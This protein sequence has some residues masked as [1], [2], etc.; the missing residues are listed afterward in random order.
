MNVS[1]RE[2]VLLEA[3]L[4]AA[5]FGGTAMLAR[6]K[7]ED[8]KMIRKE[9][10]QLRTEIEGDQRLLTHR[11]KWEVQFDELK[12][13]LPEH[14]AEQQVD[15][16]WM[17]LMQKL[18][19]K[20]QVDIKKRQVLAEI[21]SGDVYEL[22][23]LCVDWEANLSSIVRFLYDLQSQGGTLDVRQLTIKPTVKKKNELRGRFLLYCAYTRSGGEDTGEAS[24]PE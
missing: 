18:A 23:I 6:P 22:P 8:W 21:K 24:P 4:A 17:R 7:F 16:Y 1:P 19:M 14:S 15:V 10:A 2:L 9:Q 11:D 20:H 12:S 3:T 5:L 13:K